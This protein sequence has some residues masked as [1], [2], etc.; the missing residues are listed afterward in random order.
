[1]LLLVEFREV[2]S[3]FFVAYKND[4]TPNKTDVEKTIA[5]ELMPEY[6]RVKAYSKS[7]IEGTKE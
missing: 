2:R 4:S 1:M 6:R 7:L 3:K 5:T